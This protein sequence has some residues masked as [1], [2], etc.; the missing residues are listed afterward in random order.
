VTLVV[1]I[2]A[3]IASVIYYWTNRKIQRGARGEK[4]EKGDKGDAG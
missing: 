3:G 1:G 4:G 2:V